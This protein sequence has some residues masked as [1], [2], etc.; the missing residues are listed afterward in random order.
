[1]VDDFNDLVLAVAAQDRSF[2][3]VLAV[4][5]LL[6]PNGA[7]AQ[8]LDGVDARTPDNVHLT[9]AGVQQIIDPALDPMVTSLGGSI[10]NEG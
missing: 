7:Y 8:T 1:M 3:S 9:H 6:S 10:F 4:N 2:V 5:S